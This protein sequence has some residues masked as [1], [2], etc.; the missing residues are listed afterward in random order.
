MEK[1]FMPITE[2]TATVCKKLNLIDNLFAF[3]I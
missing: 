3:I 1:I 2:E